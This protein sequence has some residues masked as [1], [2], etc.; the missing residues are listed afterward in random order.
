MSIKESIT[1]YKKCKN[2]LKNCKK[3]YGSVQKV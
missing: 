2:V 1:K 3:M